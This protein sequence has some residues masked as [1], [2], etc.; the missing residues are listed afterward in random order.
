MP[1]SL[2]IPQIG[3]SLTVRL[4]LREQHTRAQRCLKLPTGEDENQSFLNASSSLPTF[5]PP[6]HP[7]FLPPFLPSF[8][9][10]SLPPFL[11]P[12]LPLSIPSFLP[13]FLPSLLPSF[14]P[15]FLPSL[16]PFVRSFLPSFLSSQCL[17]AFVSTSRLVLL[18][19]LPSKATAHLHASPCCPNNSC[20]CCRRTTNSTRR[21]TPQGHQPRAGARGVRWTSE[22]PLAPGPQCSLKKSSRSIKQY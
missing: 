1:L 18:P 8:L 10:P 20:L 16:S 11:P 4:I 7:S 14:L 6:F 9:P 21:S 13:S 12:S 3:S 2:L 19:S 17:I 15:S 5:V 22:R